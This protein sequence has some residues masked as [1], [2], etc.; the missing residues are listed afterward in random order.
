VLAFV[1]TIIL[2]YVATLGWA[3]I[4]ALRNDLRAVGGGS[5]NGINSNIDIASDRTIDWVSDSKEDA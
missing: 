5:E 3:A 1:L 2:S 4:S